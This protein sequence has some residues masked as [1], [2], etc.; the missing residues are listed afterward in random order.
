MEIAFSSIEDN[1]IALSTATRE[2]VP[3]L[4]LAKEAVKQL[5]SVKTAVNF[6]CT[7]FEDNKG[8]V[9]IANVP[10]I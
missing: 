10:K 6:T 1:Y 4:V 2:M 5:V 9:D 3:I 7:F 8:A